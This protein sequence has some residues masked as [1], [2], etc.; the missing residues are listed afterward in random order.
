LSAECASPQR[1]VLACSAEL[2]SLAALPG[3]VRQVAAAGG[4]EA[5]VEGDLRLALEEACANVIAHGYPPGSPGPIEIEVLMHP[6]RIVMTVTDRG[7]VFDPAN[8][9]APDLSSPWETRRVGGL[10]LH[11][12]RELMDEVGHDTPA[13]GGNRLTM[14]KHTDTDSGARHGDRD[15]VD[16]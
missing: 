12:I 2:A 7:R 8:A 14:I 4:L 9:P 1:F 15:Q 11:L 16:R 10:G 13:G 3:L 5:D 6:G